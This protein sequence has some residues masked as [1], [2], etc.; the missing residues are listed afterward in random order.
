MPGYRDRI[1]LIR[2]TEEEGGMNLNMPADRIDAFSLRGAFAGRL[3]VDRFSR[4]PAGTEQHLSW[5]NHRWV[6]YRSLM[7]L[8]ED[9]LEKFRTGYQAAPEAGAMPFPDLIARHS[10]VPPTS[11]QMTATQKTFARQATAE[12]IRLVESW[13]ESGETFRDPRVPRPTPQL[14]VTPTF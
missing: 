1:A 8:L 11:Y 10:D 3:L 12:I 14:R 9:L 4:P 5:D 13:D 7:A 6:R 2:H